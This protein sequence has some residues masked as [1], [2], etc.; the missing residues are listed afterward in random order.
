MGPTPILEMARGYGLRPRYGSWWL[1]IVFDRARNDS[2][3]RDD[4]SS[5]NS[6]RKSRARSRREMPKNM[7][8]T[9]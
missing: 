6:I 2:K 3:S 4:A 5:Q 8:S 9:F 1:P 7:A